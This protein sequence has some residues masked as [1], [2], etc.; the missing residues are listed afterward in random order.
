MLLANNQDITALQL[1]SNIITEA[2]MNL[3]ISAKEFSH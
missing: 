1:N 2:L 3:A